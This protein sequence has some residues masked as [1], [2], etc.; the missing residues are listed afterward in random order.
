[1]VIQISM[2]RWC[3]IGGMLAGA[4]V[5]G[6]SNPPR[7]C[8]TS[9]VRYQLADTLWRVAERHAGKPEGRAIARD[10][11]GSPCQISGDPTVI[12]G[13]AFGPF[14]VESATHPQNVVISLRSGPS[15]SELRERMIARS[16]TESRSDVEGYV[17]FSSPIGFS[18][19]PSGTEGF[20]LVNCQKGDF[21]SVT[22][23]NLGKR[24]SGYEQVSPA[25]TARV[26][27]F[28]SEWPLGAI[29]VLKSQTDAFFHSIRMQK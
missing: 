18:Y 6:C 4:T 20:D 27:F 21:I 8:K 14:T 1:M 29:D 23:N 24:C 12:E 7:V 2:M 11:R 26:D 10:R 9:E 28:T 13:L 16:V 25:V 19:A 15:A 5:T 3:L 17:R 22:G